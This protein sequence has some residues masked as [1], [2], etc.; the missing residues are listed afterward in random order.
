MLNVKLPWCVLTS[1]KK[2]M[3]FYNCHLILACEMLTFGKLKETFKGGLGPNSV[4]QPIF[5]KYSNK[6]KANH[7]LNT[8]S[9][10]Y[11]VL[12][13]VPFLLKPNT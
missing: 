10:Q 6:P 2:L 5:K 3:N 4:A 13:N 8:L 7:K 9:I 12:D 1:N 11:S